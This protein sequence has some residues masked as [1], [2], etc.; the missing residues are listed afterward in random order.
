[1]LCCFQVF[2]THRRPS[3]LPLPSFSSDCAAPDPPLF[4]EIFG[5]YGKVTSV[6]LAVDKRVNLP[7]VNLG[8]ENIALSQE[9][10]VVSQAQGCDPPAQSYKAA[11]VG[12]L[13]GSPC[14]DVL[15]LGL[16][17]SGRSE[18]IGLSNAF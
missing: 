4:Q 18:R 6:D 2:W 7:K 17:E 15:R 1:M 14:I 8:C 10:A 3:P 11:G 5:S 12:G 16:C 13:R 9:V